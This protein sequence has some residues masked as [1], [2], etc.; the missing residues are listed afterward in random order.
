M[1]CDGR[2]RVESV[3]FF[4]TKKCS[5]NEC[6][7]CSCCSCNCNYTASESCSL[8][9]QTYSSLPTSYDCTTEETQT[10]CVS[11]VKDS[12]E[13]SSSSEN[14]SEWTSC[15]EVQGVSEAW[16]VTCDKGDCK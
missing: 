11:E 2:R 6:N 15:S 4:I 10:S 14:S 13:T 5:T 8:S 7:Q 12:S 9:E 1:S 16:L 3:E